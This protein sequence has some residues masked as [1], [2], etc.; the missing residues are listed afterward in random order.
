[1]ENLELKPA[2]P[3]PGF[4][5]NKRVLLT[6]HTG[7]K[8]GWLALW[9]TSMGARVCGLA[10]SPGT[11]PSFYA[12]AGVANAVPGGIGDLR[13]PTVVVA[14]VEMARPEIVLAPCRTTVATDI[15]KR[16]GGDFRHQRDGHCQP[17]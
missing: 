2:L 11:V 16:A 10:L 9:L 6:G 4:W 7:F 5:K 13:D 8:G 1:M 17:A 15:A 3:D 14:A 12:S